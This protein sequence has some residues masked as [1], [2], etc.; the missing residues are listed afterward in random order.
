MRWDP[1]KTDPG[2][3]LFL[4]IGGW[5][6]CFTIMFSYYSNTTIKNPIVPKQKKHTSATPILFLFG[7]VLVI[8]WRDYN[9]TIKIGVFP[10]LGLEYDLPVW[11]L[12]CICKRCLYAMFIFQCATMCNCKPSK[13]IQRRL[14]PWGRHTARLVWQVLL[15]RSAAWLHHQRRRLRLILAVDDTWITKYCPACIP[16]YIQTWPQ[17]NL[18]WL[19]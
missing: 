11:N 15:W 17:L 2:G 10:I 13:I 14:F 12:Y 9:V 5:T 6:H 4:E 7:G 18:L 19:V 16:W 8:G 3:N 1:N